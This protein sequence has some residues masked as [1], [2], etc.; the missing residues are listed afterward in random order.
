MNNLDKFTIPHLVKMQAERLTSKP[1]LIS[2]SETLSFE[3]LD[4]FSTN[5]ASH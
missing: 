3:D 4:N 1:A 2:E 5:I